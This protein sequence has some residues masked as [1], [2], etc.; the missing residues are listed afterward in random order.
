MTTPTAVATSSG[1]PWTSWPPNWACR[2]ARCPP[3]RGYSSNRPDEPD[4][5][6]ES[7]GTHLRRVEDPAAALLLEQRL[8][9]H[10]LFG[11]VPREQQRIVRIGIG[12]GLRRA[13]RNT[14]S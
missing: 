10:D 1:W 8:L 4:V 2:S 6:A 9:G 12:E 13:H 3:G 5:T 7:D 14:R 11:V